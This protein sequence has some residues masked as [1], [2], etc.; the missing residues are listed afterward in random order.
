MGLKKIH[1]PQLSS[2]LK[3]TL[4]HQLGAKNS[5]LEIPM[6]LLMHEF[7]HSFHLFGHIWV[8]QIP[9]IDGL[10]HVRTVNQCEN[11]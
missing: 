11:W 8:E 6:T 9:T 1:I 5:T 2:F 3:K 10:E 7:S 4:E